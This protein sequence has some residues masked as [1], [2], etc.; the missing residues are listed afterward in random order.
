M[1]RLLTD[2]ILNLAVPNSLMYLTHQKIVDAMVLTGLNLETLT[3]ASNNANEKTEAGALWYEFIGRELH[4]Q[5]TCH[6]ASELHRRMGY[7][8]MFT[9]IFNWRGI[10]AFLMLG[11]DAD[12]LLVQTHN[13]GNIIGPQGNILFTVSEDDY[14]SPHFEYS[15]PPL[16]KLP[17]SPISLRDF[18]AYQAAKHEVH[19]S[20]LLLELIDLVSNRSA[21]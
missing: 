20:E 8:I 13:A 9:D 2:T 12:I 10:E 1:L 11:V 4:F 7:Q 15:K 17:R 18:V 5:A 19:N 6:I 3:S 16:V 14:G 21:S